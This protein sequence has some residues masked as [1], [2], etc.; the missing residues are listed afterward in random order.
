MQDNMQIVRGFVIE[1]LTCDIERANTSTQNLITAITNRPG[2]E[3]P[4]SLYAESMRG[5]YCDGRINALLDVVR[6]AAREGRTDTIAVLKLLPR[7][8]IVAAELVRN[9]VEAAKR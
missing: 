2:L 8:R 9:R 6:E 7:N 4:V 5:R 3:T 1:C